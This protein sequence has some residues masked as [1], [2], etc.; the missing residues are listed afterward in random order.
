MTQPVDADELLTR[1]R[2]ARDWASNRAD[3]V[4][5]QAHSLQ[6]EGKQTEALA[7][8]IEGQTL[9]SIC[10]VLDEILSPGTHTS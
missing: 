7:S 6:A 8:S 10:A 2:G 3:E 9:Q 5:E 4:T 1:I